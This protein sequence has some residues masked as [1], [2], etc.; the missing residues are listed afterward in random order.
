MDIHGHGG[1][2]L[3]GDRRGLDGAPVV[4]LGHGGGQTRHAWGAASASLAARG[5]NALTFDLRGHGDSEWPA[6]G[7]YTIDAFVG[8]LRAVMAR[9]PEP[10]VVV[11]ASLS[12]IAG[13]VAAGE[14]AAIAM[15]AL[16]LVDITPTIDPRGIDRIVGFMQSHLG[17]GF[18]SVESAAEVIAAYLPHRRRP[19][20][21]SGLA[22]NLR[23]CADGRYRWHWDPR[24]IEGPRRS[25]VAGY[26]ERILRATRAIRIPTLLV[27]G[28]MSELVTDEAVREFMELVPH[29]QFRDVSGAGHMIAGHRN[30]AFVACVAAF[31]DSLR[32]AA[33]DP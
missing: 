30:D 22:K 21:L 29:A 23:R 15:R 5:W 31:L 12:G 20:D 24:F 13:L 9:S 10:P 16:V 18:D 2:R 6:D 26:R 4:I 8:D 19:Q 1:L 17:E 33:A 25:T 28:R 7:D 27:R 14:A 32:D 11:G 3:R